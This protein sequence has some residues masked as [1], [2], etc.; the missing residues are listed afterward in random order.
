[1]TWQNVIGHQ[2]SCILA[3]IKPD[4]ILQYN[5]ITLQMK[6][7]KQLTGSAPRPLSLATSKGIHHIHFMSTQTPNI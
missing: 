6:Q 3:V 4:N 2:P 1:M 7:S 5:K